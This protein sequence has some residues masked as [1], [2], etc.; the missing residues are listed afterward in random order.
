MLIEWFIR[1][2]CFSALSP[3]KNT[4]SLVDMAWLCTA[5]PFSFWLFFPTSLPPTV[6]TYF[7]FHPLKSSQEKAPGQSRLWWHPNAE[8]S[9]LVLWKSPALGK[10]WKCLHQLKAT[11][12]KA[13]CLPNNLLILLGMQRARRVYNAFGIGKL[14][15]MFEQ[16][17]LDRPQF[18]QPVWVGGIVRVYLKPMGHATASAWRIHQHKLCIAVGGFRRVY[19]EKVAHR[20][21][22]DLGCPWAGH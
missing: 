6:K 13:K 10:L 17:G 1:V 20:H 3:C 22:A 5:R 15:R 11:L 12:W 14:G 4:S 18:T 2:L 16:H 21:L 8:V 7:F 9:V 19:A